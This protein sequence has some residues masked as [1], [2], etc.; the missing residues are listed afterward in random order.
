MKNIDVEAIREHFP[1]L[2]RMN[3]INNPLTNGDLSELKFHNETRFLNIQ[4]DYEIITEPPPPLTILPV[5]I[6]PTLKPVAF[7]DISSRP[8]QSTDEII[9]NS[10]V[11]TVAVNATDKY[12][13]KQQQQQVPKGENQIYLPPN[14]NSA[15]WVVISM[16]IVVIMVFIASIIYFIFIK[17]RKAKMRS[18]NREFNEAENFYL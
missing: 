8:T 17:Q 6:L 1:N 4:F 13:L 14:D 2:H 16:G 10:Q 5:I 15:L 18:V 3:F 7:S 9:I 11:P 12:P